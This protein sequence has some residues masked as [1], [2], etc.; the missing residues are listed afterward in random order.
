M[1]DGTIE[2]F[3]AAGGGRVHR[4]TIRVTNETLGPLDVLAGQIP[5][6]APRNARTTTRLE[7]LDGGAAVAFEFLDRPVS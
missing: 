5:D 6:V 2:T 1:I 4:G 3:K 7:V